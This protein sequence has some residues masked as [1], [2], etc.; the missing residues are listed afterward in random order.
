MVY[1]GY[2][3][4]PKFIKDG[5]IVWESTGNG[6]YIRGSKGGLVYFI[7]KNENIRRPAPDA[8]PALRERLLEDANYVEQKQ[9]KL[10]M[11][12]SSLSFDIDHVAVEEENFWDND[13]YKFVTITRFLEGAVDK[14]FDFS[15]ESQET[16]KDL[17]I[18][19]SELIQKLHNCGVIHGDLKEPNFLYKNV[20]GRYQVYVIDF[21][22]SYPTEEVP[23]PELTPFSPGYESP[24]IV[25]YKNSEDPE[26]SYLITPATDI[27]TLGLIFHSVWTKEMPTYSIEA[28]SIGEAIAKDP[29]LVPVISASLDT[30]I[31]PNNGATYMSLINWMLTRMPEDRPTI[32]DVLKILRDEEPVNGKYIV[33]SDVMLFTG[34]WLQHVNIAVYDEDDLKNNK[35]VISFRKINDGGLKYL[36]RTE[37]GERRYTIGELISN[38]IL[39]EKGIEVCEPWPDHPITFADE[40]VLRENKISS[41]SRIESATGNKMYCVLDINGTKSFREYKSLV[42]MG[43]ASVVIEKPSEEFGEPWP[44]DNC[45]YASPKFLEEK[46]IESIERIEIGGQHGYLVKYKDGREPR[47]LPANT[48]MLLGLLVRK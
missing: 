30:T 18:K 31:G 1:K 32:D 26:N 17:F 24:E 4:D 8:S 46:K 12:M 42:A 38:G 6:S 10:K 19:M 11:L 48:M 3:V 43:I 25:C 23:L 27:F 2:T 35:G 9:K 39:K 7:K 13:D 47:T 34:L 36:V 28:A 21:D 37:E 20:G 44:E 5:S 40:S 33:G 41:I 14:H 15:K 45:N 29:E 16:K 22:N